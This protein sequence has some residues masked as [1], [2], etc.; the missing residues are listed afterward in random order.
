VNTHRPG[1]RRDYL[2]Y[3]HIHRPYRT[4]LDTALSEQFFHVAV[5][6]PYSAGTLPAYRHHD[7]LRLGA[8]PGEADL[9]R[10][11][12][13]RTTTHQPRMPAI[14]Q[15]NSSVQSCFMQCR[16]LPSDH[17]PC[18]ST[19]RPRLSYILGKF[20]RQGELCGD[21][22][23]ASLHSNASYLL[24]KLPRMGSGEPSDSYKETEIHNKNCS[25]NEYLSERN[26]MKKWVRVLSL[27]TNKFLE[28]SPLR[29]RYV[30]FPGLFR[31]FCRGRRAHGIHGCL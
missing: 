22:C 28:Y 9:Q 19:S 1:I 29:T 12:S 2:A 6:Q 27:T 7:H 23:V 21:C 15:C 16:L 30:G 14:R 11:H 17:D 25:E 10:W 18:I 3:R 13:S 20:I 8:E 31:R 26:K 5:G 24:L 4:T